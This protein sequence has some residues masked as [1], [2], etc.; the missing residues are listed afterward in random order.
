MNARMHILN[1]SDHTK[2]NEGNENNEDNSDHKNSIVRCAKRIISSI[3]S[4]FNSFIFRV[5]ILGVRDSNYNEIC[6]E[7]YSDNF[8]RDAINKRDINEEE[9]K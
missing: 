6:S 2:N 8:S 9:K 3:F 4:F 7:D 5:N 1:A